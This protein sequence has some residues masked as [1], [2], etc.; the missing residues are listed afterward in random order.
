MRAPSNSIALW[1]AFLL[2]GCSSRR[3]ITAA[4]DTIASPAIALADAEPAKSETRGILSVT[5]PEVLQ[6]L[7][8]GG[9][10]F[11]E[12]IDGPE[13]KET[14]ND[15]LARS[16]RY[17]ALVKTLEHDI[18]ELRRADSN[19]GVSVGKFSHRL[20]D[21]RWLRS[22]AAR[23]EL[24]A[25]VN[26]IDRAG[27]VGGCGEV[28]FVYRLAYQVENGE[29]TTTSRLP[30]TVSFEMNALAGEGVDS[31]CKVAANRWF[32]PSSDQKTLGAWL[33]S[34]SGPVSL[35]QRKIDNLR[36]LAVNVQSVRWPSTVRPDLGGHA[37]YI[38]RGF[39]V[40]PRSGLALAPLENTPDVARL[41]RDNG[42]RRELSEWLKSEEHLSMI[43]GATASIPD[44]FLATRAVS[45]TPRGLGRKANRPFSSIF[46]V[47]DFRGL[48]WEG[49]R[50]T[51]SPAALLRRLDDLTCPGCHEARSVAGFHLLGVDRAETSSA[52]S[53]AM[54]ASPHFER[55]QPRRYSVLQSLREGKQP[56]Y[57][58]PLAERALQGDAGYGAHC[59]LGDPGF[60]TWTCDKGFSCDR[61]DASFDDETVGVC[62]PE[63]M[64]GVGDPCEWGPIVR[65]A[66]AR[67]DRVTRAAKRDCEGAC[68]TNAVGFPGGMCT[69]SCG[70]LPEAGACGKIAILDPFNAC[71]A[72]NE[73]FERCLNEHSFA[74]GLRRCDVGHPCRD[75]Y[76]CAGAMGV[77]M[78]IP[79]YFLFQLRVDGHGVPPAP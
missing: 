58:R 75:D 77:G 25:V 24:V 23:F 61:Y 5:D 18:D 59:G 74:A 39:V 53:L 6:V 14:A 38:L 60:A 41:R 45:V 54:A 10:S 30:M 12:M 8:A 37:E 13:R 57:A 71:L 21:T 76:I 2:L 63:K 78:C 4:H 73:S 65:D 35:Q 48:R 66:D 36:R 15:V 62:L 33:L 67:R 68:N 69:P 43:D 34:E 19:A 42:L 27:I 51:A 64:G 44:K 26:R 47:A 9:M 28:R 72:R 17:G 31:D 79:P 55:D 49:K 7:E 70:S 32:A 1:A 20:F 52:N 16:P 46:S 22:P 50:H 11:G 40:D 56:D 3:Q 29:A